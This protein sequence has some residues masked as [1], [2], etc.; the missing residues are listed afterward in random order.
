MGPKVIDFYI[1]CNSLYKRN[2]ALQDA[3]Q[4]NRQPNQHGYLQ[5]NV[6]MNRHVPPILDPPWWWQ[7]KYWIS[8]K[9]INQSQTLIRAEIKYTLSSIKSA[10]TTLGMT[11]LKGITDSDSSSKRKLV[12][13]SKSQCKQKK[14]GVLG[15]PEHRQSTA[16]Q[17][18]GTLEQGTKLI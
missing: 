10:A 15:V 16:E 4:S 17:V 5:I 8:I 1:S 6:F 14:E 2:W 3:A 18:P 7:C 11:G 12:L 13:G 9:Y